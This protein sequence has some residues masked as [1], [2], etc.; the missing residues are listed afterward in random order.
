[1]SKWLEKK[2][3]VDSP[4][5]CA[6]N[7]PLLAVP[8]KDANGNFVKSRVCL[9]PRHINNILA[10]DKFPIPSLSE[11][12]DR[13][14]GS[15]YFSSV[16]L[17]WSYHQFPLAQSDQEK[18]AFTYNGQQYMFR[19]TPFGLKTITSVFQR[20]TSRLFKNLP[21]VSVYVD[22]ILIHSQTFDAHV[23]HVKQVLEILTKANLTINEAKCHFGFH[24][25]KCFG[26]IVS[27]QG[28]RPDSTKF[29]L[30]ENYADQQLGSKYKNSWV[31]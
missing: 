8:K 19:G 13:V 11:L 16:D 15:A 14:A 4:V 17:E 25:L 26:H 1:M 21:Y 22:D 31:C 12:L 9:D 2:I 10:D 28:L 29:N 24:R 3:I 20:V 18:T 30:V 7:S 27:A 5:G 23:K 6:W